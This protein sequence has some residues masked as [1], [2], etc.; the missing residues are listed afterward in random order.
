MEHTRSRGREGGGREL[1]ANV[2]VGHV[3]KQQLEGSLHVAVGSDQ[4]PHAGRVVA[5]PHVAKLLQLA[6]ICGGRV[7]QVWRQASG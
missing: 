3:A 5:Q 1:R 2:D 6:L 4:S 7:H